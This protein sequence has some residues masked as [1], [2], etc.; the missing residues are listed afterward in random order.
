LSEGKLGRNSSLRKF[1]QA[2]GLDLC[3]VRDL[4]P[5]SAASVAH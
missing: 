4:L 5:I 1:G 2:R 3:V